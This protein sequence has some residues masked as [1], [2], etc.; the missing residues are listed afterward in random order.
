MTDRGAHRAGVFIEPSNYFDGTTPLSV[1]R[2][3]T[4][5]DGSSTRVRHGRSKAGRYRRQG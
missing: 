3:V 1:S 4:A 5:D 2:G